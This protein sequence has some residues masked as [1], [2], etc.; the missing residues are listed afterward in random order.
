MGFSAESRLSG[1]DPIGE[2]FHGASLA[3]MRPISTLFLAAVF[4][5]PSV[6]QSNP[7]QI[8]P[9]SRYTRLGDCSEIFSG[10]PDHDT[11]VL[12]CEGLGELPVWWSFAEGARDYLGFGAKPNTSGIYGPERNEAWAIEWRGVER[13][14]HFEPFAV[15]VRMT[16]P[17]TDSATDDRSFL[18]VY[19]LRPDGTSCVVGSSLA[20]NEEARAL[21]D[22]SR[23]RFECL[24]EPDKWTFDKD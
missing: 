21:A 4:A 5:A 19:R 23:E 3:L 16:F 2:I 8:A 10:M 12:R 17:R 9:S 1:N 20:S 15:I 11:G 24:N 7:S 6:A 22:G 14:G 13:H 18:F